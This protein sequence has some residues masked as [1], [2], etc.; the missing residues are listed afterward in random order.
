[1]VMAART[2]RC[3]NIEILG[4]PDAGLTRQVAVKAEL[5]GA[6]SEAIAGLAV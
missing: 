4:A 6:R 1:M 3:D 2:P 5:V